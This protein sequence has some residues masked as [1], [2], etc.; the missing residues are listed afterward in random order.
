MNLLQLLATGAP[1]PN[2][3][4]EDVF[5]AYTYTGNSSTQSIVNGI[6]LSTKGGM[7]WCKRRSAVADNGIYDT[8]R[9]VMRSLISNTTG[10]ENVAPGPTDEVYAFNSNGFSLG[11][12]YYVGINQLS[13]TN[14]SWTFAKQAKFF[15]VVT[16]TGTGVQRTV[17]HSLGIA[18]GMIM[19]KRL[20]VGGWPVWHRSL[21]AATGK[22]LYLNT[23]QAEQAEANQFTVAPTSTEFTVGTDGAVNGSGVSYVAYL[24]AHDTASTGLIQ[25]GTFTTDGSGNATVTLGWEPQYLLYKPS[26]AAVNWSIAD[27]MRGMSNTSYAS[28]YTNTSDA[29]SAGSVGYY[30]PTATG[31]TANSVSVNQPN[32]YLAIRRG[33]MAL[34]TVGTQVYN[35]IARTGTGAAATVTGVGFPPDLVAIFERLQAATAGDVWFDRLRGATNL[36]RTPVTTAEA[37]DANTLTGL[38][39]MDGFVLGTDASQF[40][41]NYN[42]RT[43]INHFFRRYPGVFDEVCYTGTG[44]ATTFSHNLTVVPELMIV[45]ARNSGGTTNWG[46]YSKSIAVTSVLLLNSTIAEATSQSGYFNGTAPTASVFSV[47][48]DS[49]TNQNTISYAAYLFATL[50]GISKVG[51]YTG[52]GTNQTINCGFAAGARFV[53]IKRTDSTG[54]WVVFDSVRG[55]I[56]GNDP[57]LLLNSTAAEDTDEDAVDTDNSGF[58]VNETTAANVNTNT[59]TYIYLAFS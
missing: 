53:L 50:A 21:S 43:Y 24:F 51:T 55:I 33:P 34:P 36:I 19:I 13:T 10:A 39:N 12:N 22:A 2:T 58:I 4:I 46:V 44:S 26:A 30:R 52:N 15:D 28:L 35:A 16:Y 40:G 8:A 7:V 54:N 25:C 56:A 37:T 5:S 42:T 31:F 20:D 18:P 57:Y 27:T 48:T 17:P 47:G 3:N 45:K 6:D 11:T 38:D 9:G 32:I 59:A 1:T 14:V 49:D 41:V 23:T 29:E